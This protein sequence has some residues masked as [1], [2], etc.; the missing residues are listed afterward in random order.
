MNGSGMSEDIGAEKEAQ[1]P[2]IVGVGEGNTVGGSE[3]L[4]GV[5]DVEA[6]AV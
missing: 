2:E 3:T 5:G 6:A 4:G 1:V